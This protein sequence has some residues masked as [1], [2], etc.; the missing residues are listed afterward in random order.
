MNTQGLMLLTWRAPLGAGGLHGRFNMGLATREME[1]MQ[2]VMVHM[3][4]H[5]LANVRTSSRTLILAIRQP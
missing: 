3:L 4:I 1:Q 5:T 2:G